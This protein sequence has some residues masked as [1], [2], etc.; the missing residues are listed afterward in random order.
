VKE[1]ERALSG[2]ARMHLYISARA[3]KMFARSLSSAPFPEFHKGCATFLIKTRAK[4]A[5]RCK[6]G[7]GAPEGALFAGG[8]KHRERARA[9]Q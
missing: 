6:K 5:Q 4:C 2:G 7:S 9:S 3:V 1:R 8:C